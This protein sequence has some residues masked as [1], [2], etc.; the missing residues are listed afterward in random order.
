MDFILNNFC[1]LPSVKESSSDDKKNAKTRISQIAKKMNIMYPDSYFGTLK[2]HGYL[3]CKILGSGN[4]F[5]S[6]NYDSLI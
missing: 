2:S 5:N 3:P 6:S 1:I 4:T